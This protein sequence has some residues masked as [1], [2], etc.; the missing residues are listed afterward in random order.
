MASSIVMPGKAAEPNKAFITASAAKAREKARV[1]NGHLNTLSRLVLFSPRLNKITDKSCKHWSVISYGDF[2]WLPAGVNE[3]TK[4][5]LVDRTTLRMLHYI[6]PTCPK[7]E[8]FIF[9]RVEYGDNLDGISSN[10]VH[11]LIDTGL[12]EE[13]VWR[14]LDPVITDH[15]ALIVAGNSP[16]KAYKL[17]ANSWREAMFLKYEYRQVRE[18]PTGWNLNGKLTYDIHKLQGGDPMALRFSEDP[19]YDP[20]LISG[21]T[22]ESEDADAEGV[23]SVQASDD[24]VDEEEGAGDRHEVCQIFG[25][26]MDAF[27]SKIIHIQI[28]PKT[29]T[30]TKPR[31]SPIK[32]PSSAKPRQAPRGRSRS[33]SKG[34]PR[35]GK[36]GGK[37]GSTGAGQEAGPPQDT[38]GGGTSAGAGAGGSGGGGGGKDDDVRNVIWMEF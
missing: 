7:W 15:T 21:T 13:D 6:T 25:W 27:Y 16:E 35:K 17:V 1:K 4:L 18:M 14:D 5:S 2:K 26:K 33:R 28:P 24:E 37:G 3:H 11:K 38:T 8:S 22:G 20:L 34:T 31:R 23:Q 10:G 32:R 19:R 30:P 29:T 36:G 12:S 9:C